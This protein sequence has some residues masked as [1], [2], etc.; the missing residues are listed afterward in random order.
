MSSNQKRATLAKIVSY[1]PPKLY[2]GKEWYI[3][4]YSFDPVLQRLR[5]KRIKINH[6]GKKAER[7]I[8][9]NDLIGRIY[10]QLRSGW[11]P[12]IA[13]ENSKSYS[14]FEDGFGVVGELVFGIS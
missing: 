6:A 2:T 10:D 4:W 12:W 13:T 14:T 1:S 7:R 8:Y 3:G 9:A 11:N 5:R